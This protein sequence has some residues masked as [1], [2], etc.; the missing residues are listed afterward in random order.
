MNILGQFQLFIMVGRVGYHLISSAFI[1]ISGCSGRSS[2]AFCQPLNVLHPCV[3]SD[4]YLAHNFFVIALPP[5]SCSLPDLVE[6][7]PEHVQLMNWPKFQY[8]FLVLTKKDIHSTTP[9]QHFT[10]D[11]SQ[12]NK[13]RK[14]NERYTHQKGRYKTVMFRD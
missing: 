6:S 7:C 1:G 12:L 14:I 10:E 8:R 11:P 5:Q 4:N 2:H 3:S 13:A 9:I